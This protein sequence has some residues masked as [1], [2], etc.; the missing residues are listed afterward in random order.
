MRVNAYAAPA[1]GEPLAPTT[2]ERREVGAN[3]VLIEI[4]YAGICHSDIH[5]VNGD[6]GPQPFPV[7]PGHEIVGIVTEVGADVTNH[8]VGDRVGVGC[9]VN[10]CGD[11]RPTA[12]TATSSTALEGMVGTYAG[13]DRDGTTTQGGYSTHVVVDADYVLS[14]PEGLDPAAAAPL[15]CAGI[16]TYSPLRALGRRSRQEGRGRRP[17]RPRPHGRQDRPRHGRRGHRAVAV[18]EEAGGRPPARR[19]PLLRDLATPTPSRRCAAR[20]TSSSTPSARRSTSTPTSACSPSTARWS[21]SA[22]RPSR[23]ASTSSA[24][25]SNGR[26]FAGSMIGG[27]AADPGDARLLRRAR[28]RRRGRGHRRRPGQRGLRARARLR[29]AL[30]LRDRREHDRLIAQSSPSA[31]S[32]VA[33]CPSR[34]RVRRSSFI[35]ASKMWRCPPTRS[36]SARWWSARTSP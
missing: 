27:I 36:S 18:A 28:H 5:T 19:G 4:E 16:T 12:A 34:P 29:R 33:S 6:W 7:V 20:S 31:S 26:S 13:T 35:S 2:I 30:P 17:R 14:V 3:D 15:L 1:A 9:M 23:S 32:G 22:P 10:S 11:V 8:Q 21:T 24:C 25:S